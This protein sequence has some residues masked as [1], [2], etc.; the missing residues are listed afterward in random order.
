MPWVNRFSRTYLLGSCVDGKQ[1]NDQCNM[2]EPENAL[3]VFRARCFNLMRTTS[4][5]VTQSCS[6]PLMIDLLPSILTSHS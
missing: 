6:S 3:V 4:V 5:T 2:N 1:L